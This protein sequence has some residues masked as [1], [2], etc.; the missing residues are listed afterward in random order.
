VSFLLSFPLLA[1]ALASGVEDLVIVMAT[2]VVES[3]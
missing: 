3:L 1:F 2:F